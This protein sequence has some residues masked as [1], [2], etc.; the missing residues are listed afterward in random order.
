MNTQTTDAKVIVELIQ[1]KAVP[2]L[3]TFSIAKALFSKNFPL[4]AASTIQK[5][6]LSSPNILFVHPTQ[7]DFLLK[8]L[9]YKRGI[10]NTKVSQFDNATFYCQYK[11]LLI[12][13]TE[14]IDPSQIL[15]FN[16]NVR[17]V[18]YVTKEQNLDETIHLEIILNKEKINTVSCAVVINLS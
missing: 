4:D 12:Y 2:T 15:V 6:T 7:L 10:P 16:Y 5:H 3:K 18:E 9:N 11:G 1:S 8:I 13:T 14:S 17:G